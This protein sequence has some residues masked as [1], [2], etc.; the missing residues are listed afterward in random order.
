MWMEPQESCI[1]YWRETFEWL[2][3]IVYSTCKLHFNQKTGTDLQNR[4][5]CI[6]YSKITEDKNV[7]QMMTL[8]AK[9]VKSITD[10][11]RKRLDLVFTS[12]TWLSLIV[13]Q[14]SRIIQMPKD[15]C[16]ATDSSKTT[17]MLKFLWKQAFRTISNK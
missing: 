1:S 7:W 6:Y 9:F 16:T 3:F 17:P 5:K 10:Y 12:C 11:L 8:H 13:L 4:T 2:T 14:W 15:T